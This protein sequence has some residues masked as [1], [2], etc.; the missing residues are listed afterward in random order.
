[1]Q[2]AFSYPWS[3]ELYDKMAA[4]RDP[5]TVFNW[6][7]G[8]IQGNV[9]KKELDFH[10][11][12]IENFNQTEKIE[13]LIDLVSAGNLSLLNAKEIAYIIIDGDKRSATSI[14]KEKGLL[15]SAESL[16]S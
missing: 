6:L 5:K 2:T 16:N 8:F 7:Y 10:Q 11:V 15:G 12:I 13:E 1:V 4:S 3:I 14:V 9:T